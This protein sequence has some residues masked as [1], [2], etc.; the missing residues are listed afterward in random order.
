MLHI[1]DLE[2]DQLY[3][4]LSREW[5]KH[6]IPKGASILDIAL[7]ERHCLVFQ[8]HGDDKLRVRVERDTLFNLPTGKKQL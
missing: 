2:N 3:P 5:Q 8:P 1:L 7:S 6:S 4:W